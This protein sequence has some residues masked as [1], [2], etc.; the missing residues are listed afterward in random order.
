ME[1]ELYTQLAIFLG[2][3]GIIAAIALSL[4]ESRARRR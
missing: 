1:A 3:V 4:R 2:S